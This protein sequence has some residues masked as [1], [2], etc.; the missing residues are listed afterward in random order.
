MNGFPRNFPLGLKCLHQSKK[1]NSMNA[2]VY[3][4]YMLI[5]GKGI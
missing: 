5:K 1:G 4:I 2:K 3:Y